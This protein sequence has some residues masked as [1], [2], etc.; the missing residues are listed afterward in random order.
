MGQKACLKTKMGCPAPSKHLCQ[1][2]AVVFRL[3]NTSG[4]NILFSRAVPVNFLEG[5]VPFVITPWN[6]K[7]FTVGL[8]RPSPKVMSH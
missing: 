4:W 1:P 8:Y 5:F 7:P 6:V 2:V 3:I